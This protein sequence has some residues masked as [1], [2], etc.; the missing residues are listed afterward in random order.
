MQAGFC[1][2]EAGVVRTKNAV[3]VAVKNLVD[4]F[5]SI[6]AF[7]FVGFGTAFGVS[8]G[9]IVG[10]PEFAPDAWL[11]PGGQ[12]FAFYQLA[13]CG[14]AA[15]IVSG[16]VTERIRT[17]A[18]L[19]LSTVLATLIYPVAAHWAWAFDE[20]GPTGWLGRMGFVDYSGSTI[21]HGVGAWSALAILLPLGASR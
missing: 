12:C 8:L 18:Y 21:I 15:T 6:G 20:S 10:L 17:R 2:L 7:W 14:A 11:G 4:L 9:G 19:T 1:A 3:H 13:F 16:A 5:V